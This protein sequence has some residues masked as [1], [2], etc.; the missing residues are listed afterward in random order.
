MKP[1]VTN[2]RVLTWLCVCPA[3]DSIS[4]REK[5]SYILLTVT[6]FLIATF[7]LFGSIAYLSTVIRIDLEKSLTSLAQ[8]SALSIVTYIFV[9]MFLL[10]NK[11]SAIFTKLSEIYKAS[12]KLSRFHSIIILSNHLF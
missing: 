6:T 1:L 5:L 9:A 10:R 8:I 2:N 3:D 4:P 12:K 11:I 7:I